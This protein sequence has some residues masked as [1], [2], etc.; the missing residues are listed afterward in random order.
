MDTWMLQSLLL[1]A[2]VALVAL[3]GFFVAAEFALVKVRGSR[4]AEM[5]RQ[6]L[7]FAKTAQ[8]MVRR[9]DRSLSACQLGITMASL[10]LGWIG[11]PAVARLL[12]PA[13]HAVGIT[14]S[15]LRHTLAFV[16]GF[17]IITAVHI[18]IGEQAPKIYAIRR[19]GRTARWSSVPLKWFYVVSYPLLVGLNATTAFIL[20]RVGIE[21]AS[22]HDTPHSEEEIRALLSQA[23]AHGEVTR[24]E[25]RLIDAVFDFDEA[26]SRQIMLPR[27][28]V[29][30]FDV[31]KPFAEAMEK[32]KRTKHTRYPLCDG[33]MDNIL[34]FVHTKDLLGLPADQ[35]LDLRSVCRPPRYVPETMPLTRLLNLFR[36]TRHHLAFVVDEYGA[37]AGIVTLENVLE[38]IVGPLQDEFDDE[39][40]AVVTEGPGSYL[41]QG[42]A[43]IEE[44][45]E[46]LKMDLVAP[47]TETI[48]GLVTLQL[49]RIAAPGD[50]VELEGASAEVLEVRHSRASRIRLVV[51]GRGAEDES[52]SE[53]P[54]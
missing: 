49:G 17:T 40:P 53:G 34:G 36:A 44:V 14:S 22:D 12:Q 50:R 45:N 4:L 7:P 15:G 42:G 28:D 32:A 19:P 13:F 21:G 11:E 9:L 37:V 54:G 33:S 29:E 31:N 51:P 39:L 3:N 47:G 10:G 43:H 24:A 16:I 30:F 2:T 20:R 48:A 6:D 5:A 38:R 46:A 8:W 25:H 35:Q 26:I 41:V 27:I 18:V 1:L 23:H 52:R